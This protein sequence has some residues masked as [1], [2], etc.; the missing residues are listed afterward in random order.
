M[1]QNYLTFAALGFCRQNVVTTINI[2]FPEKISNHVDGEPSDCVQ[3]V[4]TWREC[5]SLTQC[6]THTHLHLSG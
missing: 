6:N 4:E 1:D 2:V 3:R 5:F